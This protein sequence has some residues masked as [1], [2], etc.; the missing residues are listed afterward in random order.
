MDNH[1]SQVGARAVSAFAHIT[2]EQSKQETGE[3]SH[4]FH[5][6]QCDLEFQMDLEMVS[7]EGSPE[8]GAG[9]MRVRLDPRVRLERAAQPSGTAIE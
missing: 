2:Q 9:V 3:V 7:H 8:I 5:C 6:M 4:V 1:Y